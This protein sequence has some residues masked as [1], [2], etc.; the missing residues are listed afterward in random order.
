MP[1]RPE[2]PLRTHDQNEVQPVAWSQATG[3]EI[4]WQRPPFAARSGMMVCAGPLL[5]VSELLI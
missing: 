4:A 3:L 5:D 2:R 1:A